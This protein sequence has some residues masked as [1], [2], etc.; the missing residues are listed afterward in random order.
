MKKERN[1]K[2][3]GVLYGFLA[4][5][6]W[7]LLPLYWKLIKAVPAQEILAHRMFW[8]FLYVS[9]LLFF[10]GNW[11]GIKKVLA[12]KKKL[13]YITLAAVIIGINWFTYIYGVNSG[14][15]VEAS[16]GYYINPLITVLLGVTVLKERL[17]K[18]QG[19]A[20]ILAASGVILMTIQYGRIP[21][22]A[23]GLAFSFGFYGLIKKIVKVDS[24]IGLAME[25][26]I[27]MPF[28]LGYILFK[29]G[30]GTGAIGIIPITTTIFLLSSGVVTATPLLWFAK[31]AERIEL[32]ML[33]FIQYVSPTISLILG[34][35]IFHEEFTTIHFWGFGLIWTALFIYSISRT[36]L[37]KGSTNFSTAKSKT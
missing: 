31:S 8:S 6:A 14:H 34:V 25:T 20:L 16:L 24:M 3:V 27:L 22:I 19:F 5:I 36:S 18:W 21:W 4:Y 33:G 10:F 15:V 12:D 30:N 37:L 23:L 29:Q 9:G 1:T 32:S 7:G 28:A 17:D 13:V 35:F 11:K 26:A 2:I